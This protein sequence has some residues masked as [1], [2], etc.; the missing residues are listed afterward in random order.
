MGQASSAAAACALGAD[1]EHEEQEEEEGEGGEGGGVGERF[2]G[3]DLTA[4]APD[5]CLAAVFQKLEPADR[6][7][8]SLV[9]KRWRRVEG[10]AR[11][12]LSLQAWLEIGP[13]LPALLER[14]QHVTK[15]TL[16]CDRK[17]GSIDDDALCVIGQR[18][19]QLQKLKLKAC[20][21]LT[22]SG[23]DRFAQVCGPLQ[24]FSCA[25]CQFGPPG[26]NS[27][28]QH[29]A[30][31][32]DLTVKRLRGFVESSEFVRPGTCSIR[33]LCLKDLPN[34]QLLGPLIAGSK[35]LHTLM[36]SRVS[37]NWDRLF[38]AITVHMTSLIELHMEKVALTDQGLQAVA[39]CTNLQVLYVVKPAE[40]TNKGLSSIANGCPD[41]RKLHVDGW[42]NSR[43]G[44]E[45]LA[46]VA[47]KC[48]DLQEL[49]IIGLN[50]TMSSLSL[51]ASNCLSLERLAICTSDTFGDSEL[52]CIADKCLALKKLCIKG[53]PISDRGMEALV[54]GCPSLVKI[55][56]KKCRAVTPAS[57]ASLLSN[58]VS[59]VV[60]LDTSAIPVAPEAQV[61][62]V[63]DNNITQENAP[64]PST[65]SPLA[66]ARFAMAV[67]ACT[68][69]RWSASNGS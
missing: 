22:D 30:N 42:K 43:V 53:C 15:L 2:S 34:A 4:F 1:H 16:K 29:C 50:A 47:R 7:Q 57:I 24:K 9:S 13:A 27:I 69:M 49:V 55:K 5:E 61:R 6:R 64:A 38:E 32:E 37:G 60:T 21:G 46:T 68:F 18:C 26:L 11:Q 35:N 41:L 44:D 66:R 65:R 39:R 33:R 62:T 3:L 56:V 23:I 59:L 48:K 52:S 45:G 14:F 28:L 36:L 31:L 58:R 25:S 10:Q 19:Q 8:C 63:Q 20:K 51:L 67:V 54:G 40:C 12:R 17:R